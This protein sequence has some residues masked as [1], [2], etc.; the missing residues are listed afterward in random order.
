VVTGLGRGGSR[1]KVLGPWVVL[2][3][4]LVCKHWLQHPQPPLSLWVLL[5][6]STG[7]ILRL[8]PD[9]SIQANLG[10]EPV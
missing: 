4:L 10:T 6:L 2:L 5:L 1:A 3:S 9:P 8:D 7:L